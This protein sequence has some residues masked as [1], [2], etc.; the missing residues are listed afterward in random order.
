LADL[1]VF[2]VFSWVPAEAHA[3]CP[4]VKALVGRI[5]NYKGIKEWIKARPVTSM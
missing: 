1:Q 4:K 5:E 3:M 2:Q